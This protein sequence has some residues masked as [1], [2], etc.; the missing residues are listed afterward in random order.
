MVE[1]ISVHRPDEADVIDHF[2]EVRKDFR[3]LGPALPVPGEFEARAEGGGVG[4]DERV[5]LSADDFRRN[6]LPLEF[7]QRR[8]VIEEIE[9]ARGARHEEMDDGPGSGS[10]VRRLC[11]QGINPLGSGYQPARTER[12]GEQ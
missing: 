11:R 1:L 5:P 12:L 7:R 10:V 6:R 8:L 2:R 9:M 4:A 3:Q